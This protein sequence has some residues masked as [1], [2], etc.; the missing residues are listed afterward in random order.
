MLW[1][2]IKNYWN[3]LKPNIQKFIIGIGIILVIIIISN[4]F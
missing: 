3:D 4:I 1:D 2:N